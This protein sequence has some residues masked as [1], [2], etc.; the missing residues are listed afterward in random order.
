MVKLDNGHDVA[1]ARATERSWKQNCKIIKP[2]LK[3]YFA[4]ERPLDLGL[5]S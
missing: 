4:G 3:I 2:P 5:N 1:Y